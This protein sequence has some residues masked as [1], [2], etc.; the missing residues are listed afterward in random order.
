MGGCASRGWSGPEEAEL[1]A[2]LST[3]PFDGVHWG[4]LVFDPATGDTLVSRDAGRRFVPA[5]N[6]KILTTVGALL[7]WGPEH[8]FATELWSTSGPPVDGVLEGD[9][10]LP[11]TGDPTLSERFHEEPGAALAALADSLARVGVRSVRGSLVVDASRWDSTSVDPTWMVGDL[12]YRYASTGGAF[13]VEEGV[14]TVRVRGGRIGQ[15]AEVSWLPIGDPGFLRSE[16]R[17]VEA[18]DSTADVDVG[19]LPETRALHLTG[20]VAAGT[21]DTVQVAT[22]DPVVEAG[23]ALLGSLRRRGIEVEGGLRM[24]WDSLEAPSATVRLVRM[25]S[26]DLM[27]IA[28]GILEPSQNW[29]SEQLL[30]ALGGHAEGVASWRNGRRA[31]SGVLGDSLGVDSLSLHVVDGS[32]LS[33][34]NLVT[35]RAVGRILAGVAERPWA[36]AYRDALAAPGEEDSTL[37]NRLEGLEDRIQAKTGTITHVNSLSGYVRTA[38][39]RDLVFVVLS[40]GSGL[41]SSAI[42]ERVD[43]LLRAIADERPLGVSDPS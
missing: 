2:L 22:R 4:I 29:M 12:P 10:V 15:P 19:W 31:L 20:T 1:D 6:Q 26:P 14:T 23:R 11:G 38:S 36:D 34:Y 42:R 7:T 33:A 27:A 16:V 37:E 30:R 28:K 24:A 13:A 25:E 5:S 40:N 32:G 35:P 43:I 39:G 3:A 21:V 8:R 18:D 17:T 9:L 41:R